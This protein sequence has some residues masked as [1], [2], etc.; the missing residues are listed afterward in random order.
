MRERLGRI[1]IG[2]SRAGIAVTADDLGV[3]VLS[4]SHAELPLAV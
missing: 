4:R 2:Q 3:R 1:V